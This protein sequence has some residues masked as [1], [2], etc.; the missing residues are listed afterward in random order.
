MRLNPTGVNV[1]PATLAQAA[2][3]IRAYHA[4]Q[5]AESWSFTEPDGTCLGLRVTPLERVGVY[6][7]GGKAAYPSSVLMTSSIA[8]V[9]G[10]GSSVAYAASKGALNTLT[11]SGSSKTLKVDSTTRSRR[12]TSPPSARSSTSGVGAACSSRR[13]SP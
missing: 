4:R 13:S 2:E 1:E 3:R 5:G 8:G 6:V 9:V 7:P 11:L 10:I 12:T